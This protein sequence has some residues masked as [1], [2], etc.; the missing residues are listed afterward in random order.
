MLYVQIL[1]NYVNYV[2]FY[3]YSPVEYCVQYIYVF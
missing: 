3:R 2:N 1:H